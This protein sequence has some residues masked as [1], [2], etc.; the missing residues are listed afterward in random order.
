[1]KKQAILRSVLENISRNAIPDDASVMPAVQ[2]SVKMNPRTRH[3]LPLRKFSTAVVVAIVVV[4][5]LATVGYAAYRLFWDPGL[6]G[7][8]DAGLGAK[9]NTTAQSTLLP[10]ITT[11][12]DATKPALMVGLTQTYG[13]AQVTLDWVSLNPTRLIFGF[14]AT[15]L[16][17]D[18]SIGMP[19]ITFSGTEAKQPRGASLI[20]EGSEPV[21]GEYISYQVINDVPVEGSVGL[22]IVLPLMQKQGT[23]EQELVTFNFE[24][25][26]VPVNSGQPVSYQQTYKSAVNSLDMRLEWVRMTEDQTSLQIC[27][28]LP[29][30]GQD[31]HPMLASVQYG[32]RFDHLRGEAVLA[33]NIIPVSA[34]HSQKCENMQFPLG[35]GGDAR[36]LKFSVANL[37]GGGDTRNGP[38]E[39][40]DMLP[41]ALN[42]AEAAATPT[43][44]AM[45]IKTIG[46]LTAVLQ[47][48][49]ADSHRVALLVHFD[50]WK[51]EYG[52]G[53]LSVEDDNGVVINTGY[54]VGA[55]GDDPS[56]ILITIYQN[57]TTLISGENISLHI[58][59]PV[60]VFAPQEP[61]L[62]LATFHFDLDLPVY[63]ARTEEPELSIMAN[64]LEMRL[65]RASITPSYT[66][67]VL[68]YQK[69]THGD[70]SDWMTGQNATIQIG[71]N[72]SGLDSYGMLSDSDYGGYVGK[73]TP[74]ADLPLMDNGR[75]VKL[76]FPIGDLATTGPIRVKLTVPALEK[77]MP[78]VIPDD[79]LL[80]AVEKLKAQGIEI[81]LYTFSSGGGGGGGWE[82][83]S[84]PAG[85]S[86][87]EA[88]QKFIEALGYVQAGP[89]VFEFV[90]P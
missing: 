36:V 64:G 18:E 63:Q 53:Q 33:E 48:A 40:Y 62:P 28:D 80:P 55:Q 49:Y 74:P 69:P 89:W 86:D 34:D 1:M 19:Q 65:V 56:T 90:I 76:G 61:D 41:E 78:E 82:F 11:V 31:W 10:E 35:T 88:Y 9:V 43:L 4:L 25:K 75:C 42:L 46:D 60:M 77:S 54:G 59:L 51:Q 85:M 15:G 79:Q 5:F 37:T 66:E 23:T 39:F 20:L 44:S 87:Q 2:K 58:D 17:Q 72:N 45:D 21:T 67:I 83:T 70:W 14:T 50:G 57:N 12:P 22:G 13:A 26:E 32:D 8:K 29:S 3:I 71:E 81:K 27:Y 24:V 52:I 38:W 16:A 73:G 68:C 47:W 30:D 84:K 7:V 6:Q